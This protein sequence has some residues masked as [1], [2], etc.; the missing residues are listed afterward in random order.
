MKKLNVLLLVAIQ[1]MAIYSTAQETNKKFRISEFQLQRGIDYSKNSAGTLADFQKLAPSSLLLQN[2]FSSFQQTGYDWR[3]ESIFTSMQLGITFKN[4]PNPLLRI[5]IGHAGTNSLNAN[6]HKSERFPYDTLTF[7]QSGQQV[8]I[9]SVSSQYYGMNFMAERIQLDV[10]L[11][12]RTDA[13][14]RWSLY[15]GIGLSFS[16]S[17]NAKTIVHYY[18]YNGTDNAYYPNQ[19]YS[20][21]QFT[22]SSKSEHH[23][24]TN[25]WM[26]TAS[27]PMGVDFRIGKNR[28]FWKRLHLYYELKPMLSVHNLPVIKQKLNTH[29][30]QALGMRVTF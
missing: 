29:F 13:T 17:F 22:S 7:S 27:V 12:Y 30:S 8:F 14:A 11:L 20:N 4:K 9:D 23:A 16:H 18:A 25:F 26:S 6:F 24:S 19:Y 28:E 10:A 21:G 5:G 3:N 2:D 1:L 15:A